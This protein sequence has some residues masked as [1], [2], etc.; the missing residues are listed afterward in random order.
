MAAAGRSLRCRPPPPPEPQK[1]ADEDYRIV[2]G[3]GR[4]I[5]YL[6][7][8][9]SYVA[10]RKSA[11]ERVALNVA[12][13]YIYKGKVPNFF[14]RSSCRSALVGVCIL[15]LFRFGKGRSA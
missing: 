6:C 2:A 15:L 1:G 12:G 14:S 7:S 11:G 3:D 10:T 8:V 4:L 9:E 5:Y 13:G